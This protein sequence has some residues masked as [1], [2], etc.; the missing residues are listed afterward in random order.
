MIWPFRLFNSVDIRCCMNLQH[1]ELKILYSSAFNYVNKIDVGFN[2][3]WSAFFLQAYLCNY[4]YFSGNAN[5]RDNA[6]VRGY[7]Y[8]RDNARL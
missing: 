7:A 2:T 4:S 6:Y 5:F 3:R 8:F 1:F